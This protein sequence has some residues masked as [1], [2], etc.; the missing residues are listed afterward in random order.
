[1]HSPPSRPPPISA[2]RPSF[3]PHPAASFEETG[4]GAKLS[5]LFGSGFAIWAQPWDLKTL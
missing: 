2:P 3:S 5:L 4:E 1:M